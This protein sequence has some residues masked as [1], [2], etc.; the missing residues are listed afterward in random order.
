[1]RLKEEYAD[2]RTEHPGPARRPRLARLRRRRLPAVAKP[3]GSGHTPRT[4]YGSAKARAANEETPARPPEPRARV[5]GRLARTR[6]G[7]PGKPA[8]GTPP[9]AR[10]RC[11]IR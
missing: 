2:E 9:P 5:P 3:S 7:G 10:C 8:S 4:P 11:R 1:P 6:R